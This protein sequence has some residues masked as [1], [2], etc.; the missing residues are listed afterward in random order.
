MDMPLDPESLKIL[1]AWLEPLKWVVGAVMLIVAIGWAMG[2]AKGK[3]S[4]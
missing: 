3:R 1:L 2:R 4:P